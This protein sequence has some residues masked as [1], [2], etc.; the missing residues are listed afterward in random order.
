MILLS[1]LLLLFAG[2]TV[3]ACITAVAFIQTVAGI[4]AAAGVLWATVTCL[5]AIGG[6]HGVASVSEVPFKLAVAG[7]LL[8]CYWLSCC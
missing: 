7:G 2:A 3:V 8:C 1:S 4:L 6:L 5:P